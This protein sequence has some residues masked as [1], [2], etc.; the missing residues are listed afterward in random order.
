MFLADSSSAKLDFAL[1]FLLNILY[2]FYV[3]NIVT[4]PFYKQKRV[5]S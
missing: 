2:G 5:R 1:G 4:F 3:F